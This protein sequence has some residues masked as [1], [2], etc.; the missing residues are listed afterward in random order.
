MK[1][2]MAKGILAMAGMLAV[3]WGLSESSAAGLWPRLRSNFS[4]FVTSVTY[5]S[6]EIALAL[7]TDQPPTSPE[8]LTRL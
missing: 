3:L 5:V 8:R 4:N 7:A 2:M 6:P 1:T